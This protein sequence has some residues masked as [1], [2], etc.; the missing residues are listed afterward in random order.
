MYEELRNQYQ[1]TVGTAL[2]ISDDEI[3]SQ[4]M[5]NTE[6]GPQLVAAEEPGGAGVQEFLRANMP[7]VISLLNT[8]S[9][10]GS[11]TVPGAAPAAG[12]KKA[13]PAVEP[14]EDYASL[15]GGQQS[16]IERKLNEN[17]PERERNS[18]RAHITGVIIA[19]PCPSEW[20][21]DVP[22]CLPNTKTASY[23]ELK[24]FD[25][26]GVDAQGDI[27]AWMQNNP[28]KSIIPTSAQLQALATK[29]KADW[30]AAQVGKQ[31]SKSGKTAT[32]KQPDWA[33]DAAKQDANL[34]AIQDLLGTADGRFDVLVATPEGDATVGAKPWHWTTRGYELEVVGEDGSVSTLMT[35]S[36]GLTD[37]LMLKTV[38]YLSPAVEN[39]L[40]ARLIN[41]RPR[42]KNGETQKAEVRSRVTNNRT[43]MDGGVAHTP[44][45]IAAMAPNYEKTVSSGQKS[46]LYY[47]VLR[48][49]ASNADNKSA[50][51]YRITRRRVSLVWDKAP[52]FA[53]IPE[54]LDRVDGPLKG[55]NDPRVKS[56]GKVKAA[57]FQTL[58]RNSLASALCADKDAEL[59][60]TQKA[61]RAEG[62]QALAADAAA[63]AAQLAG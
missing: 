31:A 24:A 49:V 36:A 11:A 18:R 7:A 58:I 34:K 62:Q 12:E 14:S 37:F 28:G 41:Y 23:G 57:D 60:S 13:K 33:K 44:K 32:Y 54:V 27:L 61:L 51:N 38:G 25:P 63:E 29:H 40:A 6:L 26:A 59:T 55:V 42:S 15:T 17:M 8:G 35:T 46:T 2:T 19:K 39:G 20:M 4:I 47:Y 16:L 21:K 22:A 1:Q 53:G 52:S 50:V 30:D 3:R 9:T 45:L 48:T 43:V 5:F 56:V 10:A